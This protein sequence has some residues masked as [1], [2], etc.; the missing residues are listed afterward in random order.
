MEAILLLNGLLEVREVAQDCIAQALREIV[1]QDLY[2]AAQV[3]ELLNLLTSRSDRNEYWS[4][5]VSQYAIGKGRCL[6]RILNRQQS[7]H[8][9]L[10]HLLDVF[11]VALEEL[12]EDAN[13][14]GLDLDSV[15]FQRRPQARLTQVKHG[16]YLG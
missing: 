13:Y 2:N 6:M 16:D 3:L 5:T 15:E 7:L 11:L 10:G 14:L 4:H 9:F 8:A 1:V 12:E